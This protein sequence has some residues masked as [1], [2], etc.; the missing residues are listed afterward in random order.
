[1]QFSPMSIGSILLP[2]PAASALR[3]SSSHGSVLVPCPFEPTVTW[4]THLVL[5]PGPCGLLLSTDW[6]N[7]PATKLSWF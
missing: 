7:W 1:M 3:T 6:Y 4:T 2:G 5:P